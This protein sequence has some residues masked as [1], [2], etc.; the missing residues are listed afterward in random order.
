MD[1]GGPELVET[2]T[3]GAIVETSSFDTLEVGTLPALSV[4]AAA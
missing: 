1:T 4:A 3:T 2:E